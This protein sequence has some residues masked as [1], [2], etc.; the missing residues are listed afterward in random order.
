[1][2]YYQQ[3]WDTFAPTLTYAYNSL[4]LCSAHTSL[5]DLVINVRIS[6]FKLQ[7]K[8]STE[9]MFTAAKQR[10]E[11]QDILQNSLDPT[12]VSLQHIKERYKRDFSRRL[13]IV[14]ERIRTGF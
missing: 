7:Y 12:R 6:E 9:K 8:V 3:D 10:T 13:F 4:L 14:P 2:K 1:M 5:L 11:M